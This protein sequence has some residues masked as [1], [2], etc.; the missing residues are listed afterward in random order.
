[1]IVSL[2]YQGQSFGCDLSKP[3]DISLEVGQAKCFYAPDPIAEPLV[4]GDFIGAVKEGAP[5]NF[6]NLRLNPHGNGTH[7]ECLG[8]ITPEQNSVNQQLTNYHF[9]AQLVSVFCVKKE[10][11]DLVIDAESLKNTCPEG[12]PPALI[13]R[14]LP[15]TSEKIGKDYSGTNPP[16]L[17]SD[18][19]RFLVEKG[20][21]HLLLDL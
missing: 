17:T 4:A 2:S 8:H 19:M 11:D 20:V 16:Y 1:M 21:Q 13:I 18:A 14:T 5:V 15:N 6:F 3:L 9:F 12:L 7:T 10:N